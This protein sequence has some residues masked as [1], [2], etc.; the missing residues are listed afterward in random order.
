MP[1]SVLNHCL[2]Y[3][4][5]FKFSILKSQISLILG[6]KALYDAHGHIYIDTFF[7]FQAKD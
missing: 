5:A 3:S 7:A 1:I 2:K 6:A 4:S